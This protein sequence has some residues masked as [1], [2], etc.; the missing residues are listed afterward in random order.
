MNSGWTS[1]TPSIPNLSDL[2]IIVISNS[3]SLIAKNY[4]TF[5]ILLI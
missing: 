1:I 5:V 2:K 3:Q 4:T